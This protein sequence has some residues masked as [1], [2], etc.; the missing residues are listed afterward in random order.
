MPLWTPFVTSKAVVITHYAVVVL[1][2]FLMRTI[3]TPSAL[4]R[5][6]GQFCPKIMRAYFAMKPTLLSGKFEELSWRFL[7]S[8]GNPVGC[9]FMT[10]KAVVVTHLTFF[11]VAKGIVGTICTPIIITQ[12]S[13]EIVKT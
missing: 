2:Q 7:V 3:G 10:R 9:M 5:Y 1:A 11:I 4:A 6:L 13:L 8:G 12:C